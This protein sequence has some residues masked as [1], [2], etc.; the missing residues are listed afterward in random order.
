MIVLDDESDIEIDE[1]SSSSTYQ[2]DEN[3]IVQ[4]LIG[5]IEINAELIVVK[6]SLPIRICTT[7]DAYSNLQ[8]THII[9]VIKI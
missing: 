3:T 1:Q 2:K 9:M 6:P 4:N 8:D 5:K 7:S